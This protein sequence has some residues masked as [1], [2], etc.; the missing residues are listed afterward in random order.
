MQKANGP[1][2]E[3]G[4]MVTTLRGIATKKKRARPKLDRGS[5]LFL[6]VAGMLALVA[7]GGAALLI[8]LLDPSHPLFRALGW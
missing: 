3:V 1:A 6:L 5:R 7:V 2:D 8:N 4:E